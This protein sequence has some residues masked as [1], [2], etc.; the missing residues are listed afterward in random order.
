MNVP[1]IWERQRNEI[2]DRVVSNE[3]LIEMTDIIMVDTCS[4]LHTGFWGFMIGASAQ[5]KATGRKIF[6]LYSAVRELEKLSLSDSYELREKS[7]RAMGL[8]SHTLQYHVLAVTGDAEDPRIN[9][10]QIIE[11]VMRYRGSKRIAVITQDYQ[12]AK[13]LQTINRLR[14]YS[15]NSVQLYKLN[16]DNRLYRRIIMD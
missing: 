3:K 16:S 13:D 12:L 11:Y 5:L 1:I 10:V 15:G 7:R 6:V 2:N 4:L 9:D 8:I 14:S